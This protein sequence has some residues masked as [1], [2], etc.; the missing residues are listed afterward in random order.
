MS[1]VHGRRPESGR[2]Q[3]LAQLVVQEL[4]LQR[5]R[6]L[7]FDSVL[8]LLLDLV[9]EVLALAR[10]E[11]DSL[12]RISALLSGSPLLRGP[13][14]SSVWLLPALLKIVLRLSWPGSGKLRCC[15]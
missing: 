6:V 12:G 3:A 2:R 5:R 13:R 4:G 14:D 10:V 15:S 11:R 9:A 1:L 7:L 8:H